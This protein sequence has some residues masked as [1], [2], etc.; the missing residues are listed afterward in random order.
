MKRK[1]PKESRWV[2][3]A[4]EWFTQFDAN[5]TP[6]SLNIK[7]NDTY[8]TGLGALITMLSNAVLIF[9][10]YVKIN[11]LYSKSDPEFFPYSV[12]SDL[13]TV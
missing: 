3:A 1:S 5:G 10:L 4:S 11:K 8:K 12:I 6:I 2:D 9:W 7:G 13:N